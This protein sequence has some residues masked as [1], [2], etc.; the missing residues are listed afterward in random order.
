MAASGERSMVRKIAR[1]LGA[2]LGLLITA[3][4]LLQIVNS[5]FN[6]GLNDGSIFGEADTLG[7]TGLF[8]LLLIAGSLYLL[9]SF[10]SRKV[11]IRKERTLREQFV[12]FE[13][14]TTNQIL[15]AVTSFDSSTIK[16]LQRWERLNKNRKTLLLELDRLN[17]RLVVPP[18]LPMT[19]SS[20]SRSEENSLLPDSTPRRRKRGLV[21]VASS[22]VGVI[23][24]IA[25]IP[26]AG[27]IYRVSTGCGAFET[28][29]TCNA[30]SDEFN[31]GRTAVMPNVQGQLLNNAKSNIKNL[32]MGLK[33][34]KQDLIS[35][36]SVWDEENWTVVAQSPQPGS[37][38]RYGALICIGIAKNDET[39]Q[40]PDRLQCWQKVENE[41][42]ASM[43]IDFLSNDLVK[44][45]NLPQSLQGSHLRAMIRIELDRGNT[46]QLPYCTYGPVSGRETNLKIDASNGGDPG[47]FS[48]GS[49]SFEAS[50][51]LEWTGSYRFTITKLEKSNSGGCFTF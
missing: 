20:E 5:L 9:V 15:A 7:W 19:S 37:E 27:M 21:V 16:R 28:Q 38:L 49:Q 40:T 41:L 14:M 32:K 12:E 1:G 51:F 6:L 10:V 42:L 4:W 26:V 24:L 25:V 39:W 8:V 13:D 36:R 46:V 17:S 48:K 43:D 34:D 30:R 31:L 18:T 50:L 3:G 33:I 23:G 47:A 29:D 35:S 45:T 22:V 2:V 44:L 11:S